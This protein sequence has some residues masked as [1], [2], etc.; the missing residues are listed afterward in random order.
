MADGLTTDV[1]G[2][3]EVV[4]AFKAIWS[5]LQANLEDMAHKAAKPVRE[6][7]VENAPELTGNL[8][9][10]IVQETIKKT[11]TQAIV[12]VGPEDKAAF[13]GLFVEFGFEPHEV[14]REQ[15]KGLPVSDTA[16]RASMQ[17]PGYSGQ[18][19]LRPAFD[20]NADRIVDSI[21]DDVNRLVGD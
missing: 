15:V 20:V 8:K 16:F 1:I 9:E 12:G 6:D 5:R 2:E 3:E 10:K 19:F 4:A 18:P 21:G 14:E 13:Y 7:A 17:H 11:S